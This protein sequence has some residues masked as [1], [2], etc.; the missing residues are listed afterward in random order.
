MN[1]FLYCDV[2]PVYM[3]LPLYLFIPS[4]ISVSIHHSGIWYVCEVASE[5]SSDVERQ[6]DGQFW[7]PQ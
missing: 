4:I 2:Y 1:D 5:A 3:L 6:R 7:I